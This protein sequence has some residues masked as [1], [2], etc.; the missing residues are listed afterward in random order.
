MPF[1]FGDNL[2]SV[3]RK[4]GTNDE[5]R[6]KGDEEDPL[7]TD[8]NATPDSLL[9]D[10]GLPMLEYPVLTWKVFVLGANF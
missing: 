2:V 9:N 5:D 3:G 7:R 6:G 10:E 8:G 1:S 4:P